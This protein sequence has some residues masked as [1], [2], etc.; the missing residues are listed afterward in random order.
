MSKVA[1]NVL[2]VE[3]WV[4]EDVEAA[5][6]AGEA[7]SV[8]DLAG[9]II[10]EWAA[11]RRSETPEFMERARRAIAESRRDPH[12]GYPLEEVFAELDARYAAMSIGQVRD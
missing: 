8:T 11:V 4:Q 6:S 12:P 10:T 1:N 9:R 3:D 2:D 5:V 7:E